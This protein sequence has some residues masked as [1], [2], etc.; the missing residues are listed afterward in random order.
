[1]IRSGASVRII[2]T[3]GR[4]EL[5]YGEDLQE[6]ILEEYEMLLLPELIPDNTTENQIYQL[7]I[8]ALNIGGLNPAS[9]TAIVND[10]IIMV[11]TSEE[12]TEDEKEP[13]IMG[14]VV[15]AYSRAF[16]SEIL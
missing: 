1:M 2:R 13:L 12:L 16:W 3:G 8:N 7:F 10:Y 5:L 6:M 15:A 4:E 9:F 11:S 14:F